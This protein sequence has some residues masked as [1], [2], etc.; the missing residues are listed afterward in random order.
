MFMTNASPVYAA[1]EADFELSEDIFVAEAEDPDDSLLFAEP[2]ESK[3]SGEAEEFEEAAFSEESGD[4]P[5]DY[6][7][8]ATGYVLPEN[9]QEIFDYTEG[10]NSFLG[11][12]S[13]PASYTTS[14]LPPLRSQGSLGLCW[15]FSTVALAEINA[16]KKGIASDIN[17]SE[18]HLAYFNSNYVT[19]PLGG[20]V[21]DYISDPEN[22][23]DG[24]HYSNAMNT[25]TNWLGLASESLVP[26]GT[27]S[28]VASRGIQNELAY[29]DRI[30]VQ[31]FDLIRMDFDSFIKSGD[32]DIL[33]PMKK[34]IMEQGAVGI[35]YRSPNGYS[36]TTTSDVYNPEYAAFYDDSNLYA[37]HAVTI[38]GWDDNFAKE[39][40]SKTPAGNGAWLIR[41]SWTTQGGL[42]DMEYAG[43]FWMSYYTNTIDPDVYSI[44]VEDAANYDNN[45][46]YQ[47]TS[48]VSLRD[49]V[50]ANVYTA[51]AE[52]GYYGEE[53]KAVGFQAYAKGQT[54]TIR[55]YRNVDTTPDTGTLV[56]EATTTYVTENPGYATVA[57]DKPVSLAAG[58]K[59]A[60]VLEGSV[61]YAFNYDYD[62][63][64]ST[65]R[66]GESYLYTNGVWQDYAESGNFVIKAFTNN[67]TSEDEVLPTDIEFTNITEES[68]K[69]SSEQRYKLTAR[70]LPASS[71]RKTITWSSSDPAVATVDNTGFLVG[72]KAGTATITAKVEGTEV[73]NS[74]TVNVTSELIAI[75]IS[76]YSISF[77]PE[78]EIT[79]LATTT[80]S[81]YKSENKIKWSSSDPKGIDISEDGK[82]KEFG[83]G[84]YTIT[85][86]LD[87]ITG[88]RD[89]AYAPTS[90]F[91]RYDI[92]SDK[93]VTFSWDRLA[94]EREYTLYDGERVVT[95][96][97]GDGSDSYEFT[98][99]YYVGKSDTSAEYKLDVIYG[100][101]GKTGYRS[102]VPCTVTFG[103]THTIT[104]HIEHATQNPKNPTSYVTGNYYELY[105]PTP[106]EGY[107][108]GFWSTDPAHKNNIS[109]ITR[110]LDKDLDLY[111]Y[112][113]QVEKTPDDPSEDPGE[114]DVPGEDPEDPKDE[115]ANPGQYAT[116]IKMSKVKVADLPAS[117]EYNGTPY[118]V[119][120]TAVLYYV[121]KS[122]KKGVVLTRSDD[123]I[124]GD[125]TVSI[126]GGDKA[127]KATI[128]FTGI[129][130]FEGSIKKTVTIKAY[131][132]NKNNGGRLNVSAEN[133]IYSKAGATP[134]VT[135]TFFNGIETIELK[136]GVD[137][138]LSYKNNKKPAASSD[139]KAP[140][141]VVKGIGNFKGKATDTFAIAPAPVSDTR[142]VAKDVK[143]KAKGK[144]GYFLSK[145]ALYQENKALTETYDKSALVYTYATDT[146]LG[147]NTTRAAGDIVAATDLVL[148][149]T[150]I[151]VSIPA[152]AVKLTA[153]SGFY[154]D[155]EN[156]M[157]TGTYTVK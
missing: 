103:N 46:Q 92:A 25:V 143:Y 36:P 55:V 2:E 41:N 86:E 90:S 3:E 89:Y 102:T 62:T 56:P 43:Y 54:V 115:P 5:E 157:I 137:Y 19:D 16:L 135:V 26:Y 153:K 93:S 31:G 111:A 124:T 60:V 51:H 65:A 61:T 142:L 34:E 112:V 101:P 18:L 47:L 52:G 15:A 139:K 85:A 66:A 91:I 145:A 45:Y 151:K 49:A 32:L 126:T 24:N 130:G 127:G 140:T 59:F 87:G 38:V 134:A 74:F 71:T 99:S 7:Q 141:V 129:N 11:N 33:A 30:H 53:L 121:D 72:K 133:A 64:H 150:V 149:G 80:P 35:S 105:V 68:L 37:N 29:E 106:D 21:G 1:E 156:A 70:V 123:G 44:D 116:R 98:D 67:L 132:F 28:Y 136:E 128:Y 146:T 107:A 58:E 148:S 155:D 75:A 117:T 118:Q 110:D 108:F 12:E 78:K 23:L 144:K 100:L 95:T 104:Y 40:F 42:N 6:I 27:S 96:F 17:L 57:L 119:P 50:A 125:Y 94:G 109:N 69:I 147:D 39:N 114:P 97:T 63:Y 9:R 14:L 76:G 4:L 83:P 81:D 22:A 131:D 154:L 77:Y 88:S 10:D 20:T 152:K 73:R 82:A 122:T 48:G 113:Y 8:G 79:F 13:F 84:C 120:D 138:K